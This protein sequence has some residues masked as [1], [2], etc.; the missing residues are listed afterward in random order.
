MKLKIEGFK[1]YFLKNNLY[2]F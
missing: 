2:H 1:I